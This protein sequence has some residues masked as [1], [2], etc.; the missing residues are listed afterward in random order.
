MYLFKYLTLTLFAIT[1][2]EEIN[3]PLSFFYIVSSNG[4][5]CTAVVI[6]AKFLLT[7][8]SC[9]VEPIVVYADNYYRY[10]ISDI[11]R[12]P[13]FT[14]SYDVNRTQAFDLALIELN[15]TFSDGSYRAVE[16]ENLKDSISDGFGGKCKVFYWYSD[17]D[18]IHSDLRIINIKNMT[19]R[20]V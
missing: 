9:I 3:K 16:V 12:Y 2:A 6:S 8:A 14:A 19:F 17:A 5:N 20:Y 4:R 13:E 10:P 11:T 7:S 18:S 1:S 15:K